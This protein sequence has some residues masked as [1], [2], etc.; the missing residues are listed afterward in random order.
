MFNARFLTSK[1]TTTAPAVDRAREI[2][3]KTTTIKG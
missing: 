1:I 2:S 3:I